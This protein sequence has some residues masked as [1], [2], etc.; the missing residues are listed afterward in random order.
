MSKSGP[1]AFVVVGDTDWWD[2]SVRASPPS[3]GVD[4]RLR[5]L[6]SMGNTGAGNS[7]LSVKAVTPTSVP[8]WAEMVYTETT[9]AGGQQFGVMD[10]VATFSPS[11]GLGAMVGPTSYARGGALIQDTVNLGTFATVATGDVLSLKLWRANGNDYVQFFKNH[12]FNFLGYSE[13]FANGNWQKG[14]G[15][16]GTGKKVTFVNSASHV[17]QNIASMG[18]V[19]SQFVFSAMLS[20][21]TTQTIQLR[22]MDGADAAPLYSQSF[23]I[24]PI[25]TRCELAVTMGAGYSGTLAVL[26]HGN[27]VITA[28]TVVTIEECQLNAGLTREP[29]QKQSGG[30]GSADYVYN[31][32]LLTAGKTWKLAASMSD[33]TNRAMFLR[34]DGDEMPN[35]P[36]YCQPWGAAARIADAGGYSPAAAKLDS[37]RVSS[38]GLTVDAYGRTV[39]GVADSNWRTVGSTRPIQSGTMRVLRYFEALIEVAATSAHT[40]LLAT[41]PASIGAYIGVNATSWG[42]AS[43]GGGTWHGGAGNGSGAIVAG[44]GARVGVIWDSVNSIWFTVN[45]VLVGGGDPVANTGA[46]YTNVT[47]NLEPGLSQLGT[48][49]GRARL[50]THAREQVYRPS[51]CVAWDGADIL[52]EQHFAGRLD[53]DTEFTASIHLP[54]PWG[55]NKSGQPLGRLS[56][57]NKD[58][59][60]DSLR[61]FDLRDS[62]LAVY[63]ML[64]G[65]PAHFATVLCDS[66]TMD[67]ESKVSI[68]S[69]GRDSK[70]DIHIDS[71]I[72]TVGRVSGAVKSTSVEAAELVWQVTHSPYFTVSAVQDQGLTVVRGTSWVYARAEQTSGFRRLVNPAGKMTSDPTV[73]RRTS[74]VAITNGNFSA[75]TGDNPN[76]WTV[77]EAAGTAEIKQN[78]G[79][80]RFHRTSG[81]LL[82]EMTQAIVGATIPATELDQVFAVITVSAYVSGDVQ[83]VGSA[84]SLTAVGINGVG[85]YYVPLNTNTSPTSIT[86]RCS[87]ALTDLTIDNISIEYGRR[88]DQPDLTW[89]WLLEDYAG[90]SSSEYSIGAMPA[91]YSDQFFNWG[92][93]FS[94]RPTVRR[95]IDKLNQSILADYYTAP[96]GKLKFVVAL[97]PEDQTTTAS[98]TELDAI[99][100]MSV[101]DDLAPALTDRFLHSIRHEQYAD[102]E[103][104]GAVTGINRVSY[105][106]RGY[107]YDP[108]QNY[109]TFYAHANGAAPFESAQDSGLQYTLRPALRD[110][111][112]FKKAF[113]KRSFKATSANS[114]NPGDYVLLQARRFGL[115]AGKKVMVVSK[116]RKLLSPK[117][118]LEFWG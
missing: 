31:P 90:F 2:V 25:P 50:C 98:L 64:D 84:G 88:T 22:V 96:D 91:A 11:G 99:G 118:E 23:V 14:S 111:Y 21:P 20:C 26:F 52:P 116:R 106:R 89:P 113:F 51:Y 30:A 15:A 112:E 54:F 114:V 19:G 1:N 4:S 93:W 13:D 94:D 79:G 34:V 6:Y 3:L 76:G 83:V 7:I 78:G 42:H 92:W 81:A 36:A 100:P 28:G 68:V 104:A 32:I 103:L 10:S 46:R 85:T 45:G 37:S 62:D 17:Q 108:V 61:N 74:T 8:R 117:T 18:I 72:V 87:T 47:G 59:R 80:A 77:T 12:R 48:T 105:T 58:G 27:S 97:N 41:A 65:L 107:P 35:M 44:A 60:Y 63:E 82:C 53:G 33:T 49:V 75:W 115:S 5:S 71:P 16:T 86:V 73:Y 55:G 43:A 67:Q 29:Y 70:L 101:R 9:G 69:R 66:L 102:S 38:A 57:S 40:G 39:T 24:G 109:H 95:I 110:M 56:I